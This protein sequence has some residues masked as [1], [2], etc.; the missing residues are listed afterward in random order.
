MSQILHVIG[1]VSDIAGVATVVYGGAQSVAAGYKAFYSPY[2]SLQESEKKL[3]KIRRRLEGLS[4]ARRNEIEIEIA[5][6]SQSL[7]GEAPKGIDTLELD[8]E[9]LS[10]ALCRLTKHYQEAGY[11]ERHLPHSML[12]AHVGRLNTKVKT[13]LDDTMTTTVPFVDDIGLNISDDPRQVTAVLA[14]SESVLPDGARAIPTRLGSP[15]AT[16]TIPLTTV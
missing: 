7:N 2:T 12:R 8:L 1:N 9:I 14:R 3:D 16:N 5:A 11:M 15:S 4:E 10:D 13:L 6:R